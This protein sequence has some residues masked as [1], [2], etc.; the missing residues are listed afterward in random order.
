MV[1]FISAALAALAIATISSAAP[2]TSTSASSTAEVSADSSDNVFD[3]SVQ[4]SGKGTWFTDTYGACNIVWDA[5][6]Q[7]IVALNAHQMGTESWGN[8][9]CGKVVQIVNTSNGKSVQ[10]TIVDKCPGNEC[11]YGSLDLSPAAF[12]Q[13]GDLDTGILNIEWHYV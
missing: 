1:K 5:E 3:T 9:V 12:Q 2:V 4:Y 7:P 8:T 13:I 11:A 6:T 10:A